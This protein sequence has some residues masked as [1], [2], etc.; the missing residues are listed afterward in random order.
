MQIPFEGH[1]HG[2]EVVSTVGGD[3]SE[4]L[5]P[6]R[7][8]LSTEMSHTFVTTI[9]IAVSSFALIIAAVKGR[10]PTGNRELKVTFPDEIGSKKEARVQPKNV[11]ERKAIRVD[12]DVQPETTTDVVRGNSTDNPSKRCYS[13]VLEEHYMKNYTITVYTDSREDLEAAGKTVFD[14]ICDGDEDWDKIS[15]GALASLCCG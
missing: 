7:S 6:S 3:S 1:W 2:R 14:T 8:E 5:E 12:S 10:N 13:R 11:F 15:A 9:V 4:R